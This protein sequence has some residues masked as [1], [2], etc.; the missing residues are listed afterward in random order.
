M[1]NLNKILDLLKVDIL[2]RKIDEPIDDAFRKF[3]H[4]QSG[5]IGQKEFG[6]IIHSFI[7]FLKKNQLIISSYTE[8]TKSSE[9]ILFSEK[10]YQGHD[11]QG[12]EGAIYDIS[13]QGGEGMNQF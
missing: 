6:N 4:S 2:Y 5:V 9:V 11:T 13:S 10:Y 7:E 12:Y 8:N 3:V 1:T